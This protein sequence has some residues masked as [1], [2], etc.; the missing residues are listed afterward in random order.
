M[1]GSTRA[2]WGKRIGLALASTLLSL[3]VGELALRALGVEASRWAHPNHLEADDK[4]ALIDAY[5]DDP[6][7]YFDL[8]LRD[9]E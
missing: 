4:R 1:A 3:L 2:L 8:D 5:P 9:A 7:G 6:R